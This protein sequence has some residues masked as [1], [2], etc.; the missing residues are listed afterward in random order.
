MRTWP[1][2]PDASREVELGEVPAQTAAAGVRVE[3]HR[4][5]KAF[6]DHLVLRDLDLVVE[7]GETFVIL[8]PSGSGKSVL[9]KHISG[10]MEPDSGEIRIGDEEMRG[11]ERTG[12]RQAMVFQSSALFNSLTVAENVGLW[13]KEHRVAGREEIERVVA[14]K[15]TLVGL[16]GTQSLMPSALSGGMKKRVSIARALAVSPQLILY[17][18]PTAGLDPVLSEQIGRVIADLKRLKITALVVTHDLH[19][20]FT[21]ADRIGMMHEGRLIEIHTPRAFFRS[22]NP[23]VQAFIRTQM[24]VPEP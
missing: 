6:G 15:L 14:E 1:W 3:V 8:G 23:E 24:T 21:V 5:T 7:A 17:D 16:A 2:G 20:A 22:Q 4:L 10:L 13:L 12:V 9:L 19:L 18:E 11:S